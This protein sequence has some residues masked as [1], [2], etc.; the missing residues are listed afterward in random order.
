MVYS[1][2]IGSVEAEYVN[3]FKLDCS[4][5]A[6]QLKALMVIPNCVLLVNIEIKYSCLIF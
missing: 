3:N 5:Q 2:L 1:L 4:Y 6:K